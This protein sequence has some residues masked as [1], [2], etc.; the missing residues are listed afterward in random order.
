[1]GSRRKV[2][3][4]SCFAVM[5]LAAVLVWPGC[6]DPAWAL[7]PPRP[8]EIEQLRT[9]NRLAPRTAYAERLG[10]HKVNAYRL[11]S[12]IIKTQRAVLRS[13]G[14]GD[15]QINVMAPLPAPPPA[16]RGMRTTGNVKVFALLIDFQDY[17]HTNSRDTMHNSLFLLGNPLQYPYESLSSY[18]R[19][20]SYNQ[21]NITGN[22]LEWYRWPGNRPEQPDIRAII[23]A[24]INHH[25][26]LGHDFSQYDFDNDGEIDYFMV[27]WSG[28]AGAWA[29]DWWAWYSFGF[30]DPSFTVDGKRLGGYAWLW[31]ATS[32]GSAFTPRVAIHETGH[33]LGL[34]D[35][36]DYDDSV[37]PRGGVGGLD[38]MDAN[39]GDH[40]CFSKWM[41]DWLTPTVVSSGS[42]TVTLG[43]TGTSQS[44]VLVWPG[45]SSGSLFTE[46]FMAQNRQRAGNDATLSCDGMLLWH[47]DARLDASGN[48]FLYNNS[49]SS[50][51]LLRLMEADGFEQIEAGGRA[52]CGDYYKS[53]FFLGPC[54]TPSSRR[55]DGTDTGVWVTDIS[56]PGNSMSAKFQIGGTGVTRPDYA[57][58]AMSLDR[59]AVQKGDTVQVT[60]SMK[61]Q[62]TAPTAVIKMAVYLSEDTTITTGDQELKK[63]TLPGNNLP[64]CAVRTETVAVTIPDVSDGN[65]YIGIMADVDGSQ[66]EVNE[67]NNTLSK[68]IKIGT[69]TWLSA[70]AAMSLT[71][72][73]LA[74]MRDFRDQ[75]LAK[76]PEGK[77]LSE[78]LYRHSDEALK[79]IMENPELLSSARTILAANRLEIS[80]SLRGEEA[81]L[82]NPDDVVAFLDAFAEKSPMSLKM[83]AWMVKDELLRKKN[84]GEILFGFRLKAGQN[85]IASTHLQSAGAIE[86]IDP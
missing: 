26:S 69:P 72:E 65:Y 19:R 68:S 42:N 48:D 32:T 29:S 57:V 86:R 55:Y 15:A 71:D 44:A 34:P 41:L 24:A 1:M 82:R 85:G 40:N 79:V 20:A 60:Y 13:R 78:T 52:D 75:R 3:M 16:W 30:G 38:M 11:K 56:N 66:A 80:K 51:K 39:Q 63:W 43:A 53:P 76:S 4:G 12:A 70:Y 58:Y 46:F 14:I 59:N 2:V 27:F 25:N 77:L 47:V 73:H 5:F 18:Y 28:L 9:E 17:V 45:A 62:G 23:K 7:Q 8:G 37:G 21:L 6:V 64:S 54:T 84:R 35:Y 61:N 31:E 81:V 83:L 67:G 10:N 49:G 22:T 36:Y 74:V 50:H 33:A